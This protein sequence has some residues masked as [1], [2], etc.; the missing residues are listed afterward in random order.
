MIWLGDKRG[1]VSDWATQR[2]VQLTGR[3]IKLADADWL[4]GP[5]GSPRGIGS[6]FFDELAAKS[7]LEIRR[8]GE[9]RGLISDFSLLAADDFDPSLVR[10]RVRAFYEKTSLYEMDIWSEWSGAFKPFGRLLALLFSRRLQQLNVPLSP[11][12]TSLGITSEVAQLIRPSTGE[13]IYTAWVRK[14]VGP[15]NILYAAAYS[16]CVIPGRAGLS[17]KVVFPLPNGNAIVLMRPQAHHDGSLSVIS[18][19]DRFGDPGFYF[20]VRADAGYVWARYLPS[21]QETITVYESRESVRADHRLT[22][23]GA[24]FLRLH[25]RLRQ[26]NQDVAARTM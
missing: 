24:Q 25:Y 7:A 13:A 17:V 6:G 3:R 22:L 15:D 9:P 2:W 4:S 18:R 5:V 14:V 8:A 19:G 11:L 23:W 1:F 10:P 12:D 20:T 26:T 21:L 16:I